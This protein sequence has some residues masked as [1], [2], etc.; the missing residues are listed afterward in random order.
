MQL[1]YFLKRLIIPFFSQEPAFTLIRHTAKSQLGFKCVNLGSS[2]FESLSEG[3]TLGVVFLAIEIMS[4]SVSAPINWE[5]IFI[6][7]SFPNLAGFLN[8]VPPTPLFL[9]L[10]LVALFIQGFQSTCRFI[11][12]LSVSYFSSRIRTAV[13][14][15]IHNQILNLSFACASNFKVGDLMDYALTG[16]D[17]I[18]I[19]IEQTSSFIV[20]LLQAATYL[21]VLVAISPWLLIAVFFIGTIVF[22]LQKI[23]LPKIRV[24]SED[25]TNK[26][27]TVNSII[28]EDIQGLRLLHSTAQLESANDSLQQNLLLLEQSLRSQA[29]KL[30]L[31]NPVSSFLPIFAITLILAASLFIIGNNGYLLPSLVTFVLAL[32]RLTIRV[33]MIAA[34]TNALADNSGRIKR[35]N[36]ILSDEDKSFRRIGGVV[37][38]KLEFGLRFESVSLRYSSDLPYAIKNLS[39]S[40]P[41]GHTLAFVGPSGAGKSS[42]ADLISGL[43]E[44]TDGSILI[45]NQ[46]LNVLD[47]Q[48][49]QMR[50]GTVSQDTF[51]FNKTISENVSFGVPSATPAM[52]KDACVSAQIHDFIQSLPEG[53]STLVGER[54]FRLSGGQRQR[55]SLARAFLREPELLILDEATSAL[56]SKNERLVQDAISR[57]NKSNSIIVIAHRLS[58]IVNAD[59]I[60]VMD[61]GSLVQSGTH[62]ELVSCDGPYLN[63][64]KMQSQSS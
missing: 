14:S 27:V 46:N 47:I 5:N 60:L 44:P 31:L 41:K 49:W 19:Q 6:I 36:Y 16:P 2:L 18:R 37:F 26:A 1:I 22:T 48:S 9:L 15:R 25:V 42:I 52:I 12:S 13:T 53:Y 33:N 57:F 3:L 56:D 17:A 10:L 32:Q 63:L 4:K 23:M 64:W 62:T 39:F 38:K 21:L 35:L 45:D 8:S 50:L 24:G 58:T 7:S 51:L 55:L 11:N 28:A 43:Y 59:Q 20:I 54:G 34:I 30:S 40:L 29:P 61:S